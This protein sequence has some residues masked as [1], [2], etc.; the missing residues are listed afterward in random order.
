MTVDEFLQTTKDALTN[1]GLSCFKKDISRTQ[2]ENIRKSAEKNVITYFEKKYPELKGHIETGMYGIISRFTVSVDGCD[3]VDCELER[4]DNCR[5]FEFNFPS[6]YNRNLE[7]LCEKQPQ[8]V[9]KLEVIDVVKKID[10]M[11]KNY[12]KALIL[13]DIL[14]AEAEL[15]RL[16][17]EL[18]D[19]EPEEKND[20]DCT[21]SMDDLDE[22]DDI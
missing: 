4:R 13:A 16:R 19:L 17:A 21:V 7:T 3:L 5:K 12:K 11:I 1:A 20:K 18:A 6:V 2:I 15:V 9:G 14:K 8:E 22:R 10:D